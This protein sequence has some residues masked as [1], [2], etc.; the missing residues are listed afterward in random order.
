MMIP[1]GAEEDPSVLVWTLFFLAQ[2]YDRCGM[3]KKA[4]ET[5]DT[6]IR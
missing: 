4:V 1:Q 6:A 5:I 2:H 3:V